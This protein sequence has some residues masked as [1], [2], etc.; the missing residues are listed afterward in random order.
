MVSSRWHCALIPHPR[1]ST[2]R[3]LK[4]SSSACTGPHPRM[5]LCVKVCANSSV[6]IFL[7]TRHERPEMQNT[8]PSAALEDCSSKLWRV[9]YTPPMLF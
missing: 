7:R 1:F 8:P 2:H 4:L 5:Y 6:R 9:R 3:V